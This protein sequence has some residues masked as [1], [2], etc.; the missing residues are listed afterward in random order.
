MLWNCMEKAVIVRMGGEI[1]V[2][3]NRVRRWYEE[4][5]ISDI[6]KVLKRNNIQFF[7]VLKYPGRA[8]IFTEESERAAKLVARVFGV[9]STSN[10]IVTSSEINEIIDVVLKIVSKK[11][12]PGTFAVRCRR[13][14][15]HSYRSKDVEKLLGKAILEN[16]SD[17]KVN[18]ENPDQTI[19]IEIRN[20]RAYI[21]FESIRGPN[22][23]PLDTQDPLISI[24]DETMES[25]LASWCIMRRG[26]RIKA[27]IFDDP[28]E[29]MNL[30]CLLNWIPD[31][32][33]DVYKSKIVYKSK[34]HK[35]LAA[36]K[37][38]KIE[39]ING[40]VSGIRNIDAESIKKLSKFHVSVL[41][42]LIALEDDMIKDW[43]RYLGLGE[44]IAD[45]EFVKIEDV[46]LDDLVYEIIRFQAP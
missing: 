35:L 10:C 4:K 40:V 31:G 28:S 8:Y 33:I 37:L 18:L 6:I 25:V 22:G 32:I 39:K 3:S 16:R 15:E 12:N 30:K 21:Y 24:I 45:E 42:P 44:Y 2:K 41:F 9:Y 27:F 11:F 29:N 26:V 13:S 43:C 7:R 36:I 14:G 1:G 20:E 19:F 38:A 23:F 5:V 46:E 34:S 17:L